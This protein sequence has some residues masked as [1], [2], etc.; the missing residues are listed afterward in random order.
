MASVRA[1]RRLPQTNDAVVR[2]GGNPIPGRMIGDS[3]DVAGMAGA[4][5]LGF[6]GG[7][8]PGEKERAR[9]GAD[10]R[11]GFA[12]GAEGQ[13]RN[14][15]FTGEGVH[16]VT[17]GAIDEMHVPVVAAG[18]QP[19]AVGAEGHGQRGASVPAHRVLWL[20]RLDVPEIDS[21][22]HADGRQ[23]PAVRA[24]RYACEGKFEVAETC[25]RERMAELVK[26]LTVRH[27]PQANGLIL[28]AGGEKLA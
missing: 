16:A 10:R 22:V 12:V 11:Q 8:V 1:G 21:F 24:E 7:D 15:S 5:A 13:T 6:L 27:L 20:P 28:A 2:R 17:A 4:G 19:A 18:R 23:D 14:G 26:F 3:D 25:G 9:C